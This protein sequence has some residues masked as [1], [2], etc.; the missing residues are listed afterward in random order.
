MKNEIIDQQNLDLFIDQFVRF[1]EMY[2]YEGGLEILRNPSKTAETAKFDFKQDRIIKKLLTNSS[3]TPIQFETLLINFHLDEE[4]GK[5]IKY[6]HKSRLRKVRTH[7]RNHPPARKRGV[8]R[9]AFRRVLGQAGT[10]VIKSIYTLMLL[11]YVGLLE[12]A[13][14]QSYVQLSDMLQSYLA[15]IKQTETNSSS[16][17]VSQHLQ[18]LEKR[19]LSIIEDYTN[20]FNMVGKG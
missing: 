9:G 5:R 7:N 3:L 4:F 6:D 16:S 13:S 2:T 14:L 12:T 10:N 1:T 15:E 18:L 8:T 20:P 11:A 17:E 19:L